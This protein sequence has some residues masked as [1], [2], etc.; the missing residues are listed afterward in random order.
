MKTLQEYFKQ[1]QEEGWAIPHFNFSTEDQL[2]AF[3]E[4]AE[5]LQTLLM[6]GTSEG[7]AKFIGYDQAAALVHSYRGDIM[8]QSLVATGGVRT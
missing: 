3:V 7:E 5:E 1:T 8:A 6:V 2:K 4:V